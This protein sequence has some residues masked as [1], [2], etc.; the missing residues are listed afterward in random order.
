MGR[1][2]ASRRAS[3]GTA[4][5]R[6]ARSWDR[7]QREERGALWFEPHAN[8][9]EMVDHAPKSSPAAT[10]QLTDAKQG[11]SGGSGDGN[12]TRSEHS[13]T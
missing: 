11:I 10:T 2:K 4:G 6:V 9:E 8:E 1:G 7:G 12:V 13:A 5:G 3:E